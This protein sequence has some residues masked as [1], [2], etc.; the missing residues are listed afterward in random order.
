VAVEAAPNPATVPD[1]YRQTITVTNTG[2][3]EATS[4]RVVVLPP[5]GT[6]IADIRGQSLSEQCLGSGASSLTITLCWDV[7][8]A[9]ATVA[10]TVV[11]APLAGAPPTLETNLVVSAHTPDPHP[12]DN[13]T[14]TVTPLAPFHPGP[15]VDLV[16]FLSTPQIVSPQLGADEDKYIVVPFAVGNR[17]S[18]DAQGAHVI[19]TVVGPVEN[20]GVGFNFAGFS[21]LGT[22]DRTDSTTFDCVARSVKSGGRASGF[23]FAELTGPGEVRVTL[24]AVSPTTEANPADNTATVTLQTG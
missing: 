22:C 20:G 7:V 1:D 2:P 14:T 5:L 12:T 23:L 17:G 3:A 19:V 15:G 13:R 8:P 10:A 18:D 16:A 6:E 4:V 24:T 9:G 21:P 11:L